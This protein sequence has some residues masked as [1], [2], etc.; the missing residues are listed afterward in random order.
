MGRASGQDASRTLP[1]GGVS[2][3][4]NREET[5]GSTQ[6]TL[7]RLYLSAGLGTPGDSPG[8]AGGS[9]WGEDCLGFP[10]E[11]AAPAT[12]TLTGEAEEDEY[13]YFKNSILK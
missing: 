6:D 3:T 2:G 1:W 12:R 11:D 10:A 7:E 13:E 8:G 9:G 4:A 5:S